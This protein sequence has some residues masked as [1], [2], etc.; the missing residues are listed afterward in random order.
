ME[1]QETLFGR[2][3]ADRGWERPA[4]FLAAF[5]QAARMIGEPVKLT[6]RQYRRWCM[7]HPPR[8][9]QRAWRVLHAMFG[10]NPADLGF[11]PAPYGEINPC[12]FLITDEIE[13]SDVKRRTFVATAMGT[14]AGATLG[15]FTPAEAVGTPH[16][17]ELRAGLRALRT[18]GDAHGGTEV[19]SLAVRHLIRIRRVIEAGSYSESIGRQLRLL[20]G[21]AANRCA[22]LHFDA[23]DQ[24]QARHYWHEA[25]AIGTTLDDDTLKAQALAML[26]L[27]ANYQKRPRQ[28]LDVLGAARRHAESI[29]SPV[30]LSIIASR[31]ADA[32][33]LM[34]DHPAANARLAQAMRLME[35]P[36]RGRR[37]P[38]WTAFYDRAEIEVSQAHML[39]EAGKHRAALPYYQAAVTHTR[40]AYGRN[41]AARQF[42]LADKFLKAGEA[43]EGAAAALTGLEHLSEVSS[44]QV[45][46][47]MVE[48]RDALLAV[49]TADA[50]EAADA[51]TQRLRAPRPGPPPLDAA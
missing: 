33:S 15:A 4:A 51:I 31:E 7:P 42:A 43:E 28:A 35:H 6:A 10:V 11:P 40:G 27:Q 2:A 9:R 50:R 20:A 44:G 17:Q 41:L 18:L 1:Q 23:C 30:L 14:A 13:E 36:Q 45:R 12:T 46:A 5:T 32:F 37:A 49:D 39:T 25:L 29:G 26:G 8:P 3:C 48:V 22:Y 21:E 34:G 24:D 19:R 47:R 38:E 16:V